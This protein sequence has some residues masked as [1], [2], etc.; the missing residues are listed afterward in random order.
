[1]SA[2]YQ[3]QVQQ[4]GICVYLAPS[5]PQADFLPFLLDIAENKIEYKEADEKGKQSVM[6][7]IGMVVFLFLLS[8]VLFFKVVKKREAYM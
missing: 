2:I 7:F 5:R 6:V 1:M 3:L 8:I 4:L